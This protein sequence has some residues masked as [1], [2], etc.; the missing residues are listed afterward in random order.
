M[1]LHLGEQIDS[2]VCPVPPRR[3]G[4]GLINNLFLKVKR[5]KKG[6]TLYIYLGRLKPYE[7]F[8]LKSH[9]ESQAQILLSTQIAEGY[10]TSPGAIKNT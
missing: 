1:I 5:K 8:N 4:Q 2:D 7:C 9:Q 3:A 6:T 10:N